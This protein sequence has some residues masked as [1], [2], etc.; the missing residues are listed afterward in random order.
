M[1]S[2]GDDISCLD[3]THRAGRLSKKEQGLKIQHKFSL[4]SF[5]HG[6]CWQ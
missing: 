6:D 5:L 3:G 1:I 2:F 4:G